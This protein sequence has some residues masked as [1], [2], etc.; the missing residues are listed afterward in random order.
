MIASCCPS[1]VNVPISVPPDSSNVTKCYVPTA[2]VLNSLT[3][4]LNPTL[5][6]APVFVPRAASVVIGFHG[7]MSNFS[8][9]VIYLCIYNS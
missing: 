9:L 4:L 2:A 5:D 3:Y 8:L 7:P 1:N 6:A